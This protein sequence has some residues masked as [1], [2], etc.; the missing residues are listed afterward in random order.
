MRYMTH[1]PPSARPTTMLPITAP[2]AKDT[3]RPREMDVRHA[4]A[5]RPLADVAVYMPM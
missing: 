3:C 1:R 5:V 2:E 4:S